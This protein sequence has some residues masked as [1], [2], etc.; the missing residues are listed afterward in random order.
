MIDFRLPFD[1]PVFSA[2]NGLGLS[3]LDDAFVLASNPAFGVG[4]LVV[5]LLWTL[6]VGRRKA[7]PLVLLTLA[8]VALTDSFGAY[9]LKP[10]VNRARP[11]IALPP[12]TFRLLVARMTSPSM[13][14]L[15]AAN[16]F[17]AAMALSL[18]ARFIRPVA[19]TIALVIALSR[20]GVGVHW[21]SD[22]LVGA[23]YG[24]G[25]ALAASWFVRKKFPRY[26]LTVGPP[27]AD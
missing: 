26:A 15:H 19:L 25:V 14:S 9:V 12:G 16:S 6:S 8:A 23:L 10:W 7:I 13:P 22:I 24:T 5:L 17:A 18:G 21:P 2:V 4:A 3:L 20:V 1:E 27:A 11:C